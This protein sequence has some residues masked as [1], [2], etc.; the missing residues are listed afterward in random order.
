[1]LSFLKGVEFAGKDLVPL[2]NIIASILDLIV[3]LSVD[4]IKIICIDLLQI[5]GLFE[6]GPEHFLT[7]LVCEISIGHLDVES[8]VLKLVSAGHGLK[9]LLVVGSFLISSRLV[10]IDTL[11][12]GLSIVVL[13]RFDIVVV[14]QIFVLALGGVFLGDR[15]V[16]GDVD[17]LHL[18][19]HDALICLFKVGQDLFLLPVT[20][21]EITLA[22]LQGVS[23]LNL[24][25]AFSVLPLLK[26]LPVLLLGEE[27]WCLELLTPPGCVVQL[28]GLPRVFDEGVADHL[29]VEVG[30]TPGPGSELIQTVIDEGHVGVGR[31]TV[32]RLTLDIVKYQ[33]FVIVLRRG[34][35]RGTNGAAILWLRRLDSVVVVRLVHVYVVDIA[36]VMTVVNQG[37]MES[38]E[39]VIEHGLVNDTRY[40]AIHADMETGVGP[41]GTITHMRTLLVETGL[42]RSAA[43]A[44]LHAILVDLP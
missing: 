19:L 34:Q 9:N 29:L 32:E 16:I 36:V 44:L 7:D 1:M 35:R 11:P 10:S 6:L 17:V 43:K 8:A 20:L 13:E 42:C 23:H 22:E 25:E 28:H 14:L 38:L 37:L 26:E 31:I 15:L 40:E 2:L 24:G 18:S 41:E 3:H 30:L 5:L 21:F 33:L 12:H 39:G 4:L 27:D